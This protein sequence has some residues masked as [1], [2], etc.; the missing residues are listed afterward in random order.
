MAEAIAKGAQAIVTAGAA[1]SNFVRQLGAACSM[2]GLKCG[3]AAMHLPHFKA[4][5][6]PE[7]ESLAHDGGNLALDRLLGVDLR[8]VPDGDWDELEARA[9][10]IALEYESKGLKVLRL[11]VGGSSPLSAYAFVEAAAEADSQE[12]G[13]DAIVTPS[14]SGSTHAGLAYFHHGSST[15][16]IGIC[17]DDDPTNELLEHVAD[18]CR[19]L[20]NLI[21]GSKQMRVAD[22]EMRMEWFGD[23]YNIPSE[24]GRRATEVLARREG[25]FLDPI[26]GA[27]AFAGLI[28]MAAKKEISGKVL[29]WH[30]GGMPTLFAAPESYFAGPEPAFDTA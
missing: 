1:Q 25:V 9:D 26:Y 18:L 15:R 5:G 30:T 23:G 4:A 14:S 22:L 17:A 20:D 27:K 19:G 8:V 16:V 6:K 11:P 13:F 12:S 24:A 29:F 3:A 2:F 10:E 7:V 21:S 28:D